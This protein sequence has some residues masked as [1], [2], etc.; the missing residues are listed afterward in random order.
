MSIKFIRYIPYAR[1]GQGIMKPDVNG[2]WVKWDDFQSSRLNIKQM[3]KDRNEAEERETLA[4]DRAV[5]YLE[6][7]EQAEAKLAKAVEAVKNLKSQWHIRDLVND[8][9][10]TVLAEL[11][12]KT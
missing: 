3:K 2:D 1:N 12:K 7:A 10:N 11:E 4:A 9:F 6:R 5:K 8:D